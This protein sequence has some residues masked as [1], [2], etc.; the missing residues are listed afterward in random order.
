M[1]PHRRTTIRA[2]LILAG[3][4]ILA[5]VALST[6]RPVVSATRADD[7][8]VA[9]YQELLGR[10]RTGTPYYAA[11]G[12]V[13]RTRHYASREIFN[14]R[15]PAFFLAI[16]ALPDRVTHGLIVTLGLALCLLTFATSRTDSPIVRWVTVLA[17]LGI[18]V[19]L[20]APQAIVM[21]ELWIGMLL[22]L[23]ICAYRC[24]RWS[25]AVVVA[26][27]ALFLREL[28]A[29]Y[30]VAC[31]V[32]AVSRRHWREVAAWTVSACLYAFYY[33]IH[34]VHVAQYRLPTDQGHSSSWLEIGGLYSLLAKVHFTY[35]LMMTPWPLTVV[36]LILIVAGILNP[37]TVTPV[38][39]SA[40][41]FTLFFLVA[42]KS[43]DTY[44]GLVAWPVWAMCCG[45]GAQ[46]IVELAK[47]VAIPSDNP[48]GAT[49]NAHNPGAQTLA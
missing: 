5:V 25:A 49:H 41:S 48:I 24:Q 17:Q 15:T 9:A 22:G 12:S 6:E 31:A 33:A 39:W 13:L 27:L 45:F 10:L 47:T 3:L 16:A 18:L 2:I 30:C 38:R 21:S 46:Y 20:I 36:A 28:A 11:V 8:D 42:G 34:A 44:W 32:L 37:R 7:G 29:P 4:A 43:F 1:T 19:L 23:S 14:W 35:W 26:V 40:V